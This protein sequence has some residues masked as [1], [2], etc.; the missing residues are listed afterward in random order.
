MTD[1]F[2]EF[3]CGCKFKHKENA[4][5]IKD[6]DCLPKLEIAYKNLPL[7]CKLTWDL[8]SS[9]KTRG[10]FQ[11]ESNLG[12]TYSKSL[13]PVNIEQLAALTALLRPGCLS[14][15]TKITVLIDETETSKKSK[16]VTIEYLYKNRGKYK[17][18]LSYNEQTG[19]FE[20]NKVLDIIY[21]GV[22]PVYKINCRKYKRDKS[23]S[24]SYD[25]KCTLDH[26]LL[27]L[28]GWKELKDIQ[29]GERIAV[30][31]YSNK[32]RG[33]KPTKFI[34]HKSN[35]QLVCF[36]NYEYRCV[37][38]DWRESH[39]D[40]NHLEGN[41]FT[42]N[43]PENLSFLCPNHHRL[44]SEK[45]ITKD[46]VILAREKYKLPNSEYIEWAEY[47]GCEFVEDTDVYDIYMEAPHHNFIAGGV[48]VHN[49]MNCIVDGKS[50]TNHYVDRKNN[51]EP[52]TY[53]DDRLATY[54]SETFGVLVYQEQMIAMSKGLAGF[55]P[56][57]AN[58]LRKSVGKKDMKSLLS[59]REEFISGCV[60]TG[61]TDEVSNGIFDNIEYSGRYSFNASHSYGYGKLSYWTAY[62]KAHFP[63][64]FFCSALKHVKDTD[65]LKDLMSEVS[66]FDIQI[67]NPSIDNASQRFTIR[68]GYIQYG[69]GE[70]KEVGKDSVK[71]IE[72]VIELENK[73]GKPAVEFSWY[74]FLILITPNV[75]KTV[76]NNLILCGL[77]DNTGVSRTKQLHEYNTLLKLKTAK[78]KVKWLAENYSKYTSLLE[79]LIGLLE[80]TRT[81]D[82]PKIESLIASLRNPGKSLDDSQN[83]L[84]KIETELMGIAASADPIGKK[85]R[86]AN[87]KCLDFQFGKG[88]SNLVFVVVVKNVDERVVKTGVNANK[89]YANI[90]LA[91]KTGEVECTCFTKEWLELKSLV[92]EGNVLL[93]RAYRNKDASLKIKEVEVL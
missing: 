93:V 50:M 75:C 64:H 41:R 66:I 58:K 53:P 1:L 44:Y 21:N 35:Y 77:L 23:S 81:C 11:L 36:K 54:L 43:S 18:I 49:C 10:V 19:C 13:G 12:R 60:T 25:L 91:D 3:P 14:K 6:Y 51:K 88:T 40:V 27:T 87:I 80:E 33:K 31:K 29:A 26:K 69:Y 47:L 56:E 4:E 8:I 34:K 24:T 46:E 92:V 32:E 67:K 42:D 79:A 78:V 22:K 30:K 20:Q 39:L 37:F 7:D 90:K 72:Q 62:A 48:V 76:I 86:L 82:K 71:L 52:V 28:T 61:L 9:G 63:L 83:T 17:Q 68:D 38:C 55:S 57:R 89:K 59:L 5:G 65:E 2:Y 74:E 73:L 84:Y 45:I 16:R 70:I 15:D 85:D